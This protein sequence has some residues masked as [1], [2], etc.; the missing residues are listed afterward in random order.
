MYEA[1][2][3][4]R[5]VYHADEDDPLDNETEQRNHTYIISVIP[6]FLE[7]SSSPF[8]EDRTELN[9]AHGTWRW[10]DSLKRDH[11]SPSQ[12]SQRA[13]TLKPNSD[14]YGENC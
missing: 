13:Q 9:R 10:V 6:A 12:V 8:V 14:E 4:L 7:D 5:W 1:L 2:T 11:V 3:A